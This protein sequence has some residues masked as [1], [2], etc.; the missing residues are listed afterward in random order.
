[1]K[2][3]FRFALMISVATLAFVIDMSPRSA[4]ESGLLPEFSLFA[5]AHAVAGRQRRTRRRGAA[6]GYAAGSASADAAN[7]AAEPVPAAAPAPA[8]APATSGTVALGTIV[9]TLPAGCAAETIGGVQY[10]H[11]GSDYYR[12]AFQGDSLVYVA[13]APGQ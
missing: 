13:A 9:T 3:C 4:N 10:Q 12:T 2:T 5:E 1:M 11:C 8:P 6:V 7:E